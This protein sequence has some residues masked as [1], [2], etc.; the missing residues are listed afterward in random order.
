M[1]V[2]HI[3][4]SDGRT[5]LQHGFI[6]WLGHYETIHRAKDSKNFC[7]DELPHNGTS[8]EQWIKQPVEWPKWHFQPRF[9]TGYSASTSLSGTSKGFVT[10][11]Y[12]NEVASTKSYALPRGFLSWPRSSWATN[13]VCSQRLRNTPG[14]T[15]WREICNWEFSKIG[16]GLRH[17]CFYDFYLRF[18][19][20]SYKI[21]KKIYKK[22][23]ILN[24]NVSKNFRSFK[25][26]IWQQNTFEKKNK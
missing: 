6:E 13:K 11:Y 25:W 23:R 26:Q 15:F 3:A 16:S 24:E 7:S 10:H 18:K 14:T 20:N 17:F 1:I 8:S 4:K 19:N 12:L 22:F 9:Y 21:Y 5:K 2:Y